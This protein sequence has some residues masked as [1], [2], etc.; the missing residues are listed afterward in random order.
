MEQLILFV[1]LTHGS[2][3]STCDLPAVCAHPCSFPSSS[4]HLD[5]MYIAGERKKERKKEKIKLCPIA[6][7]ALQSVIAIGRRLP[8]R[9]SS[10]GLGATTRGRPTRAA[11]IFGAEIALLSDD[12]WARAKQRADLRTS[13]WKSRGFSDS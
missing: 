2:Q 7:R 12:R 4:V 11:D 5:D 13:C 6:A 1:E 8:M 9:T 3:Q 10:R